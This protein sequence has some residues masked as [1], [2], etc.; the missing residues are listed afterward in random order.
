MLYGKKCRALDLK[1]PR[2]RVDS[3]TYERCRSY[4]WR[5]QKYE[6]KIGGKGK[7][8]SEGMKELEKWPKKEDLLYVA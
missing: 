2:G 8:T 3:F 6:G 4:F 5:R 7:V 1:K